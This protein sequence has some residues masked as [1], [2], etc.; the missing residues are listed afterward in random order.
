[1]FHLSEFL[2]SELQAAHIIKN[3]EFHPEEK[4]T[5]E[6]V[7]KDQRAEGQSHERAEICQECDDDDDDDDDNDG[8]RMAEMQAEWVLLLRALDMASSS[9]ITHVLSEVRLMR[10]RLSCIGPKYKHWETS[11]DL[12]WLCFN[13]GGVQGCSNT[14]SRQDQASSQHQTQL[15]TVGK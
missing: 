7:E 9:D 8:T 11:K 5:G 15:R 3:K 12:L 1:M 6:E 14:V 2:I 13:A 4:T 10:D